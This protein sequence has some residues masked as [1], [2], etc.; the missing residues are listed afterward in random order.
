MGGARLRRTRS[1]WMVCSG[2]STSMVESQRLRLGPEVFA[3]CAGGCLLGLLQV[4]SVYTCQT[5]RLLFPSLEEPTSFLLSRWSTSMSILGSSSLNPEC[6][7]SPR[8]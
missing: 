7:H 4:A 5:S 8:G 3:L 1:M 2:P 6:R